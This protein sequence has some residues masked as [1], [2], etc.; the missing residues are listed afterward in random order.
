MKE[1]PSKPQ[2]IKPGK[3]K[4][5]RDI[6]MCR[7]A[8]KPEPEWG[9]LQEFA[10]ERQE[11]ALRE[12]LER[13][14]FEST[15]MEMALFFV[16]HI[17]NPCEVEVKGEAENN[18]KKYIQLAKEALQNFINPEAKKFLEDVIKKYER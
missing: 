15:N 14:G 3:P 11:A 8:G 12:K 9:P 13:L 17:E 2:E 5:A 16:E 18:R 7:P 6:E 10:L 1:Q 4:P